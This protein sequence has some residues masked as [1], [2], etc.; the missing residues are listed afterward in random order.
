MVGHVAEREG[1]LSA[2]EFCIGEW[3]PGVC[4]QGMG[5]CTMKSS[6]ICLSRRLESVEVGEV[7][8]D[9]E[10]RVG[11]RLS[12]VLG[13]LMTAFQQARGKQASMLGLLRGGPS[14]A[15]CA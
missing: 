10:V 6:A 3:R 15:M 8:G 7:H 4:G 13:S 11:G 2:E 14:R 1:R 12:S 9:D 5:K